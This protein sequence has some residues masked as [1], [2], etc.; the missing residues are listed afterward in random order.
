M[1]FSGSGQLMLPFVSQ[2]VFPSLDDLLFV[3]ILNFRFVF[4]FIFQILGDLKVLS[5]HLHHPSTVVRHMT[6]RVFAVLSLNHTSTTLTFF[7][8]SVLPQLGAMHEVRMRQGAVE[9]LAS[10]LSHR[11]NK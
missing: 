4:V 2:C 8:E 9:A 5:Q 3:H 10:I 11:L 6:A 7:I 1:A